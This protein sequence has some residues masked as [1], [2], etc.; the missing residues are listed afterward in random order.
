[1]GQERPI[2]FL[3]LRKDKF[4]QRKKEVKLKLKPKFTRRKI[5]AEK[6]HHCS[7]TQSACLKIM[8]LDNFVTDT[9]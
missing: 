2:T 4:N 8:N 1:M 6:D 5:V 3:D 7:D 9:S